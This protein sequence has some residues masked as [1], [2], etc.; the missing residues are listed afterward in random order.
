MLSDPS[1]NSSDVGL[2][3]YFKQFILF[4]CAD[5]TPDIFPISY[6][7]KCGEWNSR[8]QYLWN[9]IHLDTYKIQ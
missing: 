3:R 1:L 5:D 4:I 7:R 2:M 6:A 8:L 9:T